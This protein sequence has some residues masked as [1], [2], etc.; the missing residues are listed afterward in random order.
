MSV[1]TG[2]IYLTLAAV[3]VGELIR[4]RRTRGFSHFGLAFALMLTT[5]GLHHLLHRHHAHGPLQAAVSLGVPPAL[6][7]VALR[8]E[9]LC[10]RRGD[11]LIAR[12]PLWL[13]ALP[14]LMAAVA[15]AIA[16]DA[17]S[18]AITAGI[19]PAMLIPNAFLFINYSL[20]GL[21]TLRT[22]LAR[23]PAMGG[24]SLSGLALSAVFFTCGG[25]HLVSGLLAAP[26]PVALVLDNLAVPASFYFL[27]AVHRLHRASAR[28]WNRRPLVGRPAPAGRR[29][30]W[31]PEAV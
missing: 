4:H 6:L 11:R 31:A 27:W 12:T 30:P 16:W 26:D 13:Q 10:G 14:V 2:L 18:D 17:I 8:G 24:W 1:L 20:V 29:S 15:G 19:H 21:F 22:Q 7:F 9:A 5:C 28:D 25:A 23:R 3:T